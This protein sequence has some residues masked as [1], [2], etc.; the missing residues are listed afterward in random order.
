MYN[1][2]DLETDFGHVAVDV[3]QS[4]VHQSK[5]QLDAIGRKIIAAFEPRPDVVVQRRAIRVEA[6]WRNPTCDNAG[7]W[8]ITRTNVD[9]DNTFIYQLAGYMRDDIDGIFAYCIGE[10]SAER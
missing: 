6:R 7:Y 3:H 1:R 5:Y 10:A 9:I 4:S 8:S 2:I